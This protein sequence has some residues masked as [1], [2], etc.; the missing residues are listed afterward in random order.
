MSSA[1]KPPKNVARPA[2]DLALST[3]FDDSFQE[4]D[5]GRQTDC[6]R[7]HNLLH[8]IVLQLPDEL[9]SD[10]FLHHIDS[11]AGPLKYGSLLNLQLVCWRFYHVSD[12]SPRL[13]TYI[14]N[15]ITPAVNRSLPLLDTL[16]EKSRNAPLDITLKLSARDDHLDLLEKA[17]LHCHRWQTF[18]CEYAKHST[19]GIASSCRLQRDMKLLASLQA[20]QLR[21]FAVNES[22]KLIYSA[23]TDLL[24]GYAPYLQ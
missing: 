18:R 20:P 11:I 15:V 24:G 9:I 21:E 8:S 6:P 5:M 12:T 22:K 3:S 7:H 2:M 4:M 14:N 16:L 19:F 13:W 1:L 10:I 23:Q 17:S